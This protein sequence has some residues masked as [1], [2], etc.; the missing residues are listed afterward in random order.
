MI[1]KFLQFSRCLGMRGQEESGSALVELALSVPL[2]SMIL[3]GAGEFARVS[4]AAIEVTNAARAAAQYAATN[5]GAT[6]DT[7]GMQTAAQNDAYNLGTTVTASV[8]SDTCVCS[9]A[10][11]TTVTCGTATCSSGHL[12]ETIGI[13]TTATFNPLMSYGAPIWQI[14]GITG[15]FQLHGYSK[16]MV[17]PQ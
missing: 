14:T 3:L 13:K 5:G 15:P 2:L 16:Q 9:N 8:D 17:L 1:R 11:S 6:S 7:G 12:L 4:Y 10:E